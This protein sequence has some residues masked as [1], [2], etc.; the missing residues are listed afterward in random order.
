MTVVIFLFTF[1]V[2]PRPDAN[3]HDSESKNLYNQQFSR[4]DKK[5]KTGYGVIKYGSW[6]QPGS[7][8]KQ[9]VTALQ[10][11]IQNKKGNLSPKYLL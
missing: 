5:P 9:L 4:W 7:F 11:P 1:A 10:N 2:S 6:F 3:E 8:S